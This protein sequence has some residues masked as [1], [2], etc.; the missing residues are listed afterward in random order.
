MS[1]SGVV[2]ITSMALRVGSLS[3]ITP[4]HLQELEVTVSDLEHHLDDARNGLA[5]AEKRRN[6][7][8]SELNDCRTALENVSRRICLSIYLS[9]CLTAHWP[10][11]NSD[12]MLVVDRPSVPARTPRVREMRL[13][14]GFRSSIF[15]SLLLATRRGD[16]KETTP[17]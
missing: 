8:M 6:A 16:W 12:A 2:I 7:L 11:S 3:V 5:N 10:L 15:T 17:R 4:V 13:L 1:R 9:I 14:P